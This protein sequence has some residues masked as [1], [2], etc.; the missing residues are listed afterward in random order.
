MLIYPIITH[1]CI[2]LVYKCHPAQLS[3]VSH[4][5]DIWTVAVKNIINMQPNQ[6]VSTIQIAIILHFI[7]NSH[8]F[9]LHVL[10]FTENKNIYQNVIDIM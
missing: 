10:L 9:A 3:R 7:D 8:S 1:A 5:I 2:I 4:T 6:T